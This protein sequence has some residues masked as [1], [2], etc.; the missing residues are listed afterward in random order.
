MKK[1]KYS[2]QSSNT[3][4]KGFTLIELLVVVLIIGILAAIALPQYKMAVAKAQVSSI[5]P[6]MRRWTDSLM[7]YKLVHGDYNVPNNINILDVNWPS[8]WKK[9]NSST[10]LTDEPCNSYGLCYN[11]YWICLANGYYNSVYPKSGYT[12]CHHQV[13]GEDVFFDIFMYPLDFPVEKLRGMT[14]C[15]AKNAQGEKYCQRLGG[16]KIEGAC[17]AYWC[18]I[19]KL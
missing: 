19:Y 12:R 6:I 14:T 3:V 18:I 5:L 7:E 1:E 8:S 2:K 15:E 17:G 10:S 4:N 16:E 11:N 13:S 9:A